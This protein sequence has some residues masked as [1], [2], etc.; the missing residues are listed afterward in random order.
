M[1]GVVQS[2]GVQEITSAVVATASDPS[3]SPA[4]P[5]AQ[6]VASISDHHGHILNPN[7][8]WFALV[9]IVVK[10]WLYRASKAPCFLFL[11]NLKP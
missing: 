8:A 10:E 11:L 2:S 7:A 3:T 9:S 1:M 4:S 6:E 5:A